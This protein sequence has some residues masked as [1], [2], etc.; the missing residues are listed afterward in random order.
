MIEDAK[1]NKKKPK[2]MLQES[3][4]NSGSSSYH[5]SNSN[6]GYLGSD[7]MHKLVSEGKKL[8][9]K[10]KATQPGDTFGNVFSIFTT[11]K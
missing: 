2:A 5:A 11:L 3:M 1:I 6:S 4:Q 7:Q 8:R 10:A 9:K